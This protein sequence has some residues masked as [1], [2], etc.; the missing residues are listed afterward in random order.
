MTYRSYTATFRGYRDYLSARSIPE[1]L[2]RLGLPVL[3][4]FGADDRRWRSSSAANYRE[5]PGARV[6]MLPGVGH[7]PMVEDP[8]A[9]AKLL[10]E[11]AAAQG[12]RA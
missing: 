10:L 6:E 5:V 8:A 2:A 12:E 7:T 11:F 1:R 4:I 9:T 3:V